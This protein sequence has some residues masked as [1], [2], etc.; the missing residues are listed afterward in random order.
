MRIINVQDD[1][2]VLEKDRYGLRVVITEEEPITEYIANEGT[3]T[4]TNL[5][6]TIST[7]TNCL[8]LQSKSDSFASQIASLQAQKEVVDLLLTEAKAKVDETIAN[9]IA[10]IVII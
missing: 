6:K 10:P 9:R 1:S 4:G 2:N 8:E 5:K 3:I 7:D